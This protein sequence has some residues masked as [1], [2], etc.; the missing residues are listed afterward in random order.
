MSVDKETVKKIAKLANLYFSENE[1]QKFTGD[2]NQ[3]LSYVEKIN[4]LQTKDINPTFQVIPLKNVY[5]EDV[6]KK[7]LESSLNNAPETHGNFFKVPKII[8]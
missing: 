4:T 7:S 3:I 6:V 2:L 5:R 1:L 8:D